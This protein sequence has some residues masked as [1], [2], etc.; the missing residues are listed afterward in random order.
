MVR[1]WAGGWLPTEAQWEWTARG[2][3]RNVF[4]WGDAWDR[5]RCNSAEYHS[6]EPFNDPTD[7]QPWCEGLGAQ[8][9]DEGGWTVDLSTSLGYLCGVGSFP[10]GASWCDALDM[11][12]NV[13]E[14][15]RD[16]YDEGFYGSAAGRMRNP[17]SANDRSNMRVNRGG[18][19]FSFAFYCRSAHRNWLNPVGRSDYQGFRLSWAR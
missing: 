2:P 5:S 4:P 1:L 17:L 11:S 3:D 9:S 7:W 6:E 10:G 16:W 15:C 18:S 19:W 8:R 13:T 12:G 14:W